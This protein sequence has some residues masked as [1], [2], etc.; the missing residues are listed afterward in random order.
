MSQPQ[1]TDLLVPFELQNIPD[2]YRE[3]YAIKRHNLFASIQGFAEMWQ[4]YLRLD[5]IWL[6][7][8][9]DLESARDTTRVFPLMLY[10]NVHAK[11]RVAI[12][13]ALSGCMG[14]ARSILRD[15]IEYVAHAHH[16]LKDPLLQQI[17]LDKDAQEDAFKN[18]FERYKKIGLFNG[19]TELHDSYGQLSELGSHPT[20]LALSDRFVITDT[21]GGQRWQINYSGAEPR[22]WAMGLFSL[23][24]TCFTIEDTFFNDYRTRLQL[25]D[26][27]MTMRHD[28]QAYKERL[29]RILIQ[30]YNVAPPP[31]PLV[32][33]P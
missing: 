8:F 13:L 14:E 27:L 6:R 3:Y 17:W 22:Q 32:R 33:V 24:L 9:E 19:L 20:P 5:S 21:P 10:L 11:I 28:F 18:A 16:M 15:A 31:Q 2:K 1:E 25:D 23:L 29:R 30:R 4:Y 12:E 26:T 7:E